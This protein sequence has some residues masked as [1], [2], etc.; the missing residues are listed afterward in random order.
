MTDYLEAG[1]IINTHGVRGELKVEPWAD[2]PDFLLQ[3]G[4]FY[5][6]GVPC[7]VISSRVHT[8]FVLIRF[9][10]VDTVED[11][12]RFKGRTLCFARAD[13][14][15]PENTFFQADVIGFSVFDLRT[16]AVIGTLAEI[17]SLP[18]GDIWRVAGKTGDILIPARPEFT[19]GVDPDTRTLTV[20]TI[21]GME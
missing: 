5:V 13:A 21:P 20:E 12:M 17:L 7:R 11:A 9:A 10:G 19:R 18:A 4:T 6:D 3:F 1:R 15:L 16:N 8:R 14:K 2:S